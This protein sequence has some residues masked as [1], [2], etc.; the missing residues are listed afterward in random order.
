M[1]TI[2][3]MQLWIWAALFV[4]GMVSAHAVTRYSDSTPVLKTACGTVLIFCLV[5]TA[6]AYLL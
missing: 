1:V 2:T 4:G 5:V 3:L 6:A